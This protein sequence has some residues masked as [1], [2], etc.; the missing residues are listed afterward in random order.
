RDLQYLPA[1]AI[2]VVGPVM[3]AI[4]GQKARNGLAVN[5][6]HNQGIRALAASLVPEATAPDGLIEAVSL[7]SASTFCF[8]VQW[9]PEWFFDSDGLSTAIFQMFA[10]ACR[11]RCTSKSFIGSAAALEFKGP[12]MAH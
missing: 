8:G 10:N 4:A 11:A 3:H 2:S 7:P 1:H 12:E 9:H 6:L 5:S